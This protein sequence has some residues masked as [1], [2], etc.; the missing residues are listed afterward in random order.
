MT[1]AGP[2]LAARSLTV[3]LGGRTVLDRVDLTLAGGESVA[4]L[5]PNGAGKTTLLR[6]LLGLV[7]LAGGAV[8]LAAGPGRRLVGYV[9]QR[10]EFA[11][12]FPVS[13][14]AAVATARA[15]LVGWGRRLRDHDHQLV[16]QALDRTDLSGLRDRPLGQLS[17]GQRQRVLVARALAVQPRLLLL[18]EPFTGV[19]VATQRLLTDLLGQLAAE[20]CALL[21]A[22]HD[23]AQAAQV[24]GRYCLLDTRGVAEGSPADLLAAGPYLP[25][26]RP[27]RD[28]S[29]V[30][31]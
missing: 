3:R 18:D 20:G 25:A 29:G 8:E 15:R 28:A 19:D 12:D 14:Q 16:R 27:V 13:V 21:M 10:H 23:L 17:G 2:L 31:R 24:C 11:W 7:P 6:A 26:P 5:G 4:L 22:T 30:A 9:P 1:A